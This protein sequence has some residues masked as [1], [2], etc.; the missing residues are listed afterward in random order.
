MQV[1]AVHYHLKPGGVTRILENTA[2]ANRAA[3][4]PIDFAV[5]TGPPAKND[6]IGR[7]ACIPELAYTTEDSAAVDGDC[8]YQALM[9]GARDL[10]GSLPDIWHI[11]NHSLGKNSGM[12]GA[13]RR[14]IGDGRKVLL[15]MHDFAE[16]GRPENYK[17]IQDNLESLEDLYPLADQVSYAVINGRDFRFLDE[18]GFPN[19]HLHFLPNPVA[20]P[21]PLNSDSGLEDFLPCRELFLYPVRALRRKNLGECLLLNMAHPE[22]AVASTLGPSNP[23][24]QTQF[25]RWK[26]FSSELGL[27]VHLGIAQENDF[28]FE[29]IVSR[30]DAVISTSIAEGFGLGFIEPWLFGKP[31]IG[32]D[33]PDIT[34]DFKDAGI[35]LDHM[36]RSIPVPLDLVPQAEQLKVKAKAAVVDAYNAYQTPIYYGAEEE[37]WT[38]MTQDDC[39]DFGRL[40]EAYQ[41]LLLKQLAADD[42]ASF[43]DTVRSAFFGQ[44]ISPERSEQNAQ[45]GRDVFS[46]AGF[47]NNLLSIYQS[48]SKRTID[49]VLDHIPPRAVLASFLKP[50]RL[51]LL[52]T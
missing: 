13:V 37:A 51:N 12:A 5:L 25:E 18:A 33:I 24:Y 44:T 21:G 6:I 48:L 40:D 22:A 32:R 27:D 9:R 11:H 15:Q 52:R 43:F 38:A 49:R 10:F 50:E 39:I 16:D 28:A 20:D 47:F 41:E 46:E 7:C 23:A 42:S 30:A 19:N 1:L 34:Q 14:L 35:N 36:Y 31:L 29:A 4:E 3:G 17:L 26:A 8:L 2:R 45:V